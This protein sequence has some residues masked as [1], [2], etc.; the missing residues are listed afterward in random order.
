MPRWMGSSISEAYLL[1]KY[2]MSWKAK[3][4]TVATGSICIQKW[5]NNRKP[6]KLFWNNVC[7][8]P[9]PSKQHYG[10]P[11]GGYQVAGGS[12]NVSQYYQ[13][14]NVCPT[15]ILERYFCS[16][17]QQF[18]QWKS[19]AISKSSFQENWGL[20]QIFFT[21]LERFLFFCWALDLTNTSCSEWESKLLVDCAIFFHSRQALTVVS[22]QFCVR[23]CLRFTRCVFGCLR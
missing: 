14:G 4:S 17:R 10:T 20:I 12:W 22:L 3:C 7:F 18:W 8:F 1:S 2:D 16:V 5:T 6:K 11:N 13:H 23:S 21:S 15:A 9:S 19:E